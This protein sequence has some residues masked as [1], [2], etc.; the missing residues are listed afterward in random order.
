MYT[1]LVTFYRLDGTFA[2]LKLS[3]ARAD[4]SAASLHVLGR[5][6]HGS[7]FERVHITAI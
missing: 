2:L 1:H 4:V 6:I 5:Q 7:H 3:D